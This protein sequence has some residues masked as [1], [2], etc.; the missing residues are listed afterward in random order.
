MG[1]HHF[2]TKI[3]TAITIKLTNRCKQKANQ[4]VTMSTL[5]LYQYRTT[6]IIAQVIPLNR[7]DVILGK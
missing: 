1:E 3:M 4:I 5:Q 6:D 2:E 7:Y